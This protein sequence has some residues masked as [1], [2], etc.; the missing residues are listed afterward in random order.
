MRQGPNPPPSSSLFPP[1]VNCEVTVMALERQAVN[2]GGGRGGEGGALGGSGRYG[3]AGGPP[4]LGGN[5]LIPGGLE[6]GACDAA[7]HTQYAKF[8]E[9]P[10]CCPQNLSW[11]KR[12]CEYT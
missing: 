2:R 10:W 8:D 4:G 5:L 11:P 1:R 3:G 7:T 9:Q 6:G 12:A